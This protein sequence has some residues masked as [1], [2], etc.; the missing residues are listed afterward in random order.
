MLEA[1][2]QH[3]LNLDFLSPNRAGFTCPSL[4][5]GALST[6]NLVSKFFSCNSFLIFHGQHACRD[7]PQ[8]QLHL[9]PLPT[10]PPGR[11]QAR[12]THHRQPP[13]PSQPCHPDD[14]AFP[15]R[16]VHAGSVG[17]APP[18]LGVEG[19]RDGPEWHGSGTGYPTRPDDGHHAGRHCAIRTR[20]D[21]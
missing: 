11:G 6:Q 10:I 14:R 2:K 9:P 19:F 15:L 7:H 18:K 4:V 21:Q 16:V 8:P 1:V 20:T 3:S 12:E 17:H 5:D 13:G